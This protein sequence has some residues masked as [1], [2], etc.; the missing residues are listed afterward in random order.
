ML[1]PTSYE[2]IISVIWNSKKACATKERLCKPG[3]KDI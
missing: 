1:R 2:I 3:F